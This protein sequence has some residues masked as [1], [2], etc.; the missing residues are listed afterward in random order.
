MGFVIEDG[1]GTGKK[2]RV[3]GANRLVVNARSESIQHYTSQ[4]EENAYQVFTIVPISSGTTVALHVTNNDPTLDMVITY[5]RHQVLSSTATLP[6]TTDYY[7]I[8]FGRTYGS[9]GELIVPVNVFN[10]S[11]NLADV[12]TYC[13]NPTLEG[14]AIE[15]DRWYTKAVGDMNSFNKEGSVVIGVGNTIELSYVGTGTGSLYTRLSFLM[16]PKN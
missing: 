13:Q 16:M 2:A 10:G 11:G 3:D 15:I 9:G 14:T 5:V 8:S 4:E 6:S 12:V 1:K 7:K